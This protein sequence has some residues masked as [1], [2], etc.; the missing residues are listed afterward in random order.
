MRT[1]YILGAG[2]SKT[3]GIATDLE[4]LD[5]LNPLLDRTE[6][7]KDPGN[8]KTSIEYFREQNF[9]HRQNVGFEEFLSTLS[10]SK[11]SSEYLELDRDVFEE[12]EA[13]IQS[14]LKCYLRCKV[15]NVD[16]AGKGKIIL[17]FVEQV[18]WEHDH[19]LTFNYDLLLEAAAAK[20]NVNGFKDRIIHLHGAVDD[21]TLAWPTYT[22]FA[23]ETVKVPLMGRW[24]K[25]YD[26]LRD[27]GKIDRLA[28]IGYSMPPSD[29]EAKSLFNYTDHYN[30]LSTVH[31]KHQNDSANRTGIPEEKRYA[32]EI[33]VVNP[34][35]KVQENYEF[36]RKSPIFEE[37]T[38]EEW[39]NKNSQ[40]SA[41][42]PV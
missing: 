13:E 11:F 27:H 20:N 2:F 16:W 28:F 30:F 38:L 8:N 33:T 25:A 42:S 10:A 31:D 1:I 35:Q 40:P 34:C 32:Y 17:D 26:I 19:I 24:K 18:D 5:A 12:D 37:L 7:P 14:T 6:Q 23:H 36:F 22:K 21:D 3:C 15:E 9:H 39:L 41:T 4:M 29:L